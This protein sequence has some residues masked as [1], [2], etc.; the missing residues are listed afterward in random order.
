MKA[1]LYGIALFLVF[2]LS[3]SM[4]SKKPYSNSDTQKLTLDLLEKID[5]NSTAQRVKGLFG[6][7]SEET[8]YRKNWTA[9]TYKEKG[10]G[11]IT[12]VFENA[13]GKLVS[14]TWFIRPGEKE[15]SIENS[16]NRYPQAKFKKRNAPWINPHYGPD[17]IY[18]EDSDLNLSIEV[19]QR[20]NEVNSISWRQKNKLPSLRGCRKV[21]L[22]NGLV[23]CVPD[24]S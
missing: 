1:R 6:K 4:T 13:Q 24:N 19:S 12:L 8:I 5:L 3:C 2:V 14:K 7:P 18:Y 11:R 20:R 10:L 17:E 16:L 15:A 21:P 22:E 23:S 9:W